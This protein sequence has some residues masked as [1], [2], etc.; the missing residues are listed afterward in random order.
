MSSDVDLYLDGLGNIGH[1][2]VD[3]SAGV[4]ADCWLQGGHWRLVRTLAYGQPVLW[5]IGGFHVQSNTVLEYRNGA[6]NSI[7]LT[8]TF[9]MNGKTSACSHTSAAPDVWNCGIL[10]SATNLA[11]AAG[12]AGFGDDAFQPGGASVVGLTSF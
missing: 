1:L 9:D 7:L 8:G 4:N 6:T 11:A 12:V 10:L 5:G 2:Q 3:Q